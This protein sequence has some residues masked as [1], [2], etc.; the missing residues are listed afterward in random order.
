[1][2]HHHSWQEIF[3]DHFVTTFLPF[4]MLNHMCYPLK[5]NQQSQH[6]YLPIHPSS[7]KSMH[8]GLADYSA[9]DNTDDLTMKKIKM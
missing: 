5:C 7:L 8:V 6:T 3:L 4:P 2:K 9:M 1:M